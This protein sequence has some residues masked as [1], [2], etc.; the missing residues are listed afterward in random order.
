MSEERVRGDTLPRFSLHR[1]VT[2][3]VVF[4]ALAVLGAIAY[5]NISLELVPSGFTPPFLYVQVPTLRSSP[6]I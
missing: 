6:A 4:L 1:P 5:R 3:G 2:V